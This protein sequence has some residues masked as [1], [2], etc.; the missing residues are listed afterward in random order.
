VH[1]DPAGLAVRALSGAQA[2]ASC[3]FTDLA[4]HVGQAITSWFAGLVTSAVNQLFALVG[5]TLLAT[6]QLGQ[7]VTVRSLWAG[8]LAIAEVSYV[9]LVL[10]GGINASPLGRSKVTGD[11]LQVSCRIL[12]SSG[13]GQ[14]DE[15]KRRILDATQPRVIQGDRAD[16]ASP[17]VPLRLIRSE[18]SQHRTSLMII[19]GTYLA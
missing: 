15:A 7:I 14:Q 13:T 4:C 3:G 16:G 1:A 18:P 12:F 5:R 11:H 19:F 8:S 17:L 10:A 6:P 2:A 9:L